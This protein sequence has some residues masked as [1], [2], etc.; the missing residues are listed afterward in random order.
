MKVE[1]KD[2]YSP[3]RMVDMKIGQIAKILPNVDTAY[4]GFI[5]KAYDRWILLNSPNHTWSTPAP[6]IVIEILPPGT[7]ITLTTEN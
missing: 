7:E 6:T 2:G 5:L 4:R 1:V 3:A